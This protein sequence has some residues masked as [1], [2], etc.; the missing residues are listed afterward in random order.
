MRYPD[1]NV[2]EHKY[3]YW[4]GDENLV[5]CSDCEDLDDEGVILEDSRVLE[6]TDGALPSDAIS[7]S[8]T[9]RRPPSA[10]ET[11]LMLERMFPPD[12]DAS[13]H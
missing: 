9:S 1:G 11:L 4:D 12:E 3:R 8:R 7:V 5:I 6:A 13:P 2:Y 10:R